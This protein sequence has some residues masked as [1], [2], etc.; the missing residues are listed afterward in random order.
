M[1][2]Y[3]PEYMT[4][5]ISLAEAFSPGIVDRIVEGGNSHVWRDFEGV[6]REA[7]LV[8]TEDE[9]YMVEVTLTTA[10][11]IGP[12]VGDSPLE[13]AVPLESNPFESGD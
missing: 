12:F 2:S 4:M 11:I 3:C 8:G 13:G 6:W 10:P 7:R 1:A 9:G 5:P